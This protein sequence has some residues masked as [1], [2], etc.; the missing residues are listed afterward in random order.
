MIECFSLSKK[1]SSRCIPAMAGV[2]SFK[3]LIRLCYVMLCIVYNLNRAVYFIIFTV[4]PSAVRTM[5][6][7]RCSFWSFIPEAL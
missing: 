1:N 4:L 7:P 5:L 2:F 3:Y 6:M